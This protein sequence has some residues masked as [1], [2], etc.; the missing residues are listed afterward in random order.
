MDIVFRFPIRK[1]NILHLSVYLCEKDKIKMSAYKTYIQ[2]LS[3]DGMTYTKGSVVDLLQTFNIVAQEFP[4][5]R[6]PKSKKMPTRDW[7]GE[8][9]LDVYVPKVLPADSYDIEVEF[10]YVGTELTI[11]T[12]LSN[13]INFLFGRNA[14]AVGSRLAIY[15]EYTGLGRKDVVVSEIDDDVFYV[16]DSDPDAVA[17]FK[18]KFTIYDPTTDVVPMTA[19]EPSTGEMSVV[20]L[21]FT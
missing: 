21:Y 3:F 7:A 8:D 4:F 9:G 18:M 11:R 17:K 1:E 19:T 16:T 14:D 2:Q 12:D 6:N 20:D 15:N 13:F 10:L 5:K